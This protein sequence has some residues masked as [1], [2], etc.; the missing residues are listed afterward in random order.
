MFL[1]VS[2]RHVRAHPDGHQHGVSIQI[3]INFVKTFLRIS[4]IRNIPLTWILTRVFAYLPPYISQILNFIYWTVLIFMMIYFE[5]RD[6]ENQQYNHL[7][8]EGQFTFMHN[9]IIRIADIKSVQYKLSLLRTLVVM[10][11]LSRSRGRPRR[12]SCTCTSR[13][14]SW[15]RKTTVDVNTFLHPHF[16]EKLVLKTVQWNVIIIIIIIYCCWWW[17]YL[18]LGLLVLRPSISSLLQSAKASLL[19]SVTSVITKCNRIGWG[20]G[21]FLKKLLR[22]CPPPKKKNCYPL[23][24]FDI[25]RRICKL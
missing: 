15:T 21:E 18:L 16:F 13:Q 12:K 23:P 5:W 1:L 24:T 14:R 19:Q 17:W 3:S 8:P 25:I 9:P 7:S 2:V 10:D 22:S 4:R 20:G 6:T 11:T